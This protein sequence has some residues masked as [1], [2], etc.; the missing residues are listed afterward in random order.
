MKFRITR[1]EFQKITNFFSRNDDCSELELEP[2]A[3]VQYKLPPK[4][5]KSAWSIHIIAAAFAT[6]PASVSTKAKA[7]P[8]RGFSPHTSLMNL[9][10]ATTADTIAAIHAATS[11][12]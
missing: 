1:S 6:I 7:P 9:T 3:K 5:A 10:T 4:S 8:E 11:R 2:T 12:R